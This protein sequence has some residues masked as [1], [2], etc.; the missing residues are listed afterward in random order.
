MRDE[1]DRSRLLDMDGR[2]RTARRVQGVCCGGAAAVGSIWYGQWLLVLLV[3]ALAVLLALEVAHGRMA[4]PERASILSIGA[5]ELIIG[6]VVAG[7]GGV[8]GP[9]VGFLVIPLV[10]LAARFRQ[11]VVAL[12]CAVSSVVAADAF[13][14]AAALPPTPA[15]P[16]LMHVIGFVALVISLL[17]ATTAL[18]TAELASRGDAVLDPLTGLLNRKGLPA[19]FEQ[20]AAQARFL[21]QPLS[22]VMCDVDHFKAVND[23]HGHDRGDVVLRA[24]AD[25]LRRTLRSLDLVYR[26]GGEEFLVLLPG[27][28][29]AGAHRVAQRLVEAVGR[30]PLAGLAITLSAGSSSAEGLA[31]DYGRQ[32]R[33]ADAALYAGKKTGR[34]RA[35]SADDL[36]LAQATGE[37]TRP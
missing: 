35:V 24:V 27:H 15:V 36:V 16:D 33:L 20:A 7:T 11:H 5:F 28:D 23:A 8:R 34:N 6:V 9:F 1:L 10:M 32:L 19:R 17:A 21:D 18:L 31:I 30:F 25:E 2:V 4:H 22:V 13:A 26:V 3:A 12:G 14:T 37:P 29:A